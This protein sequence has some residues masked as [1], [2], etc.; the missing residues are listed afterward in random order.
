ML[1]VLKIKRYSFPSSFLRYCPVYDRVFSAISSGG[2]IATICPPMGVAIMDIESENRLMNNGIAVPSYARNF[3]N[4]R[5][6]ALAEGIIDATTFDKEIG[7][8]L[9][10]TE[11]DGTFCYTIFKA[12]GIEGMPNKPDARHGL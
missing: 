4:P 8:L 10:T 7:D 6:S 1:F 3:G 2:P 11:P 5:K 12:I 9:R